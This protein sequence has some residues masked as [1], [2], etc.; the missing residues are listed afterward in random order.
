MGQRNKRHQVADQIT[1]CTANFL[2][3]RRNQQIIVLKKQTHD[4][5]K[6]QKEGIVKRGLFFFSKNVQWRGPCWRRVK[7]GLEFWANLIK[8]SRQGDL[9]R[10]LGK[11]EQKRKRSSISRNVEKKLGGGGGGG[12]TDHQGGTD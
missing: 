1:P 6:K 12:S 5:G 7:G 2:K 4:K 11:S 3:N 10:D 8:D 9:Q